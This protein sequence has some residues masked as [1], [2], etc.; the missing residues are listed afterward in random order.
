MAVKKDLSKD[1]R[2]KREYNRLKKLYKEI[3]PDTLKVVDGLITQTAR[4]R[5]LLNDMWDDLKE[6]GD[7][8]MFSQSD[9]TEP[10]ERERPIARLYNSRDAA[11]QKAIKQLTDLLP[12]PST[13]AVNDDGFESFVN[14]R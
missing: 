5:I 10:Y 2:V 4:L 13:P 8:E 7:T 6:N 1:A 14:D 3:P 12:A 11:Y 9:K